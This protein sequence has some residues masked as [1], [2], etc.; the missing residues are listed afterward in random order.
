[1]EGTLS[2]FAS[3]ENVFEFC[4]RFLSRGE[5]AEVVEGRMKIPW[6]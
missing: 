2:Q 5:G 3:Q 6:T 4:V 1:M